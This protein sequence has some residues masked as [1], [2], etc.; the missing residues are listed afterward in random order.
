MARPSVFVGSS[1]EGFKIA[2]TIQ[3]LLDRSCEV[4]LWSQGVFGLSHGTLESLL[5]AIS[6][7]D[8]AI[9]V[10]TSDDL[11]IVRNIEKNVAR[12]NVIFELG[13]F[14]GALGR[15]RTFMLYDRTNKPELP[16]DLAG[17][18]ATTYEPHSTG[19]LEAA[20]GAPCSKIL[21]VI[22]KFGTR[23]EN[24][25][26]SLETATQNFEGI[27]TSMTNLI[28]LLAR[29]RKVELDII[30]SQFG[31]MINPSNL[32]QIKN[33]LEDL[34]K[35]LIETALKTDD[36]I[37]NLFKHPDRKRAAEAAIAFFCYNIKPAVK[38]WKSSATW[39]I[40]RIIY[41]KKIAERKLK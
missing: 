36:E 18:I 23:P 22:E 15:D 21:N 30:S 38:N 41:E 26:Y 32:D 35:S 7:F 29:S 5:S 31:P 34:D 24:K 20:L 1:S 11:A 33:D 39:E 19:N 8:Y 3:I 6:R 40:V 27:S 16:S 28:T 10:L 25:F 4:E 9:L 17:I 14:M 12:D 37:I 13:L 2:S